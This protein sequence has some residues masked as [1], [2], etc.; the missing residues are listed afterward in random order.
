ML[1][2][3]CATFGWQFVGDALIMAATV[4]TCQQSPDAQ[5]GCMLRTPTLKSP[6]PQEAEGVAA[7]GR[8]ELDEGVDVEGV[9]ELRRRADARRRRAPAANVLLAHPRRE[10]VRKFAFVDGTRV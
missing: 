7:L 8:L 4:L 1:C 10:R 5:V 9:L 3:I 6:S 2:L